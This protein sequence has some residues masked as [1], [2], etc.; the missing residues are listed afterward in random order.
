MYVRMPAASV[1][2][3]WIL[4]GEV[5]PIMLL[6]NAANAA[7]PSNQQMYGGQLVF[8]YSLQ[9]RASSRGMYYIQMSER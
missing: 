9:S 5:L 8:V 4:I 3:K 1:L 7:E 6:A 2:A